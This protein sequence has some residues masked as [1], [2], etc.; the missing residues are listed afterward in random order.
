MIFVRLREERNELE[1]RYAAFY[2]DRGY[3][4]YLKRNY[5]KSWKDINKAKELGYKIPPEFLEDLRKAS[6]REK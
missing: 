3:V 2:Y 6:G 4:Y 1:S 5:D